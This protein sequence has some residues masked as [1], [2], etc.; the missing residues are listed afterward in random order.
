MR[1]SQKVWGLLVICLGLL[2]SVG[3]LIGA[4]TASWHYWLMCFLGI[5][6]LRLG[7][8]LRNPSAENE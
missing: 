2:W 3:G 1:T 6:L 4:L 5:G 8:N 7:Y